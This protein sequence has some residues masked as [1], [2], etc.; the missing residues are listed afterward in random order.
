MNQKEQQVNNAD[1]LLRLHKLYVEM[2][3]AVSQRRDNAN[4]I[5]FTLVTAL[6]ILMSRWDTDILSASVAIPIAVMGILMCIVWILTICA[7]KNLNS[8]KFNV[9]LD[10]EKQLPY[11]GFAKE[12]KEYERKLQITTVEQTVP[13]IFI[14]L[15]I[16]Y[17]I[18]SFI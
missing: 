1:A 18:V 13:W 17:L 10:L 3:D 6:P 7:Y 16:V 9:I 12:W 4:K 8:A 14:S 15:F 2:A 5:F 11:A